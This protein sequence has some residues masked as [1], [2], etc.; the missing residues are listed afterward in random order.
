LEF[1]DGIVEND[2]HMRSVKGADIS[3]LRASAKT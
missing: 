2:E 3:L 1:Y